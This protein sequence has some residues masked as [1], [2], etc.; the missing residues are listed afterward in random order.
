MNGFFAKFSRGFRTP[1]DGLGLIFR[2]KQTFIYAAIPFFI[3]MLVLMFGVYWGYNYLGGLISGFITG[4]LPSSGWFFSVLS[5]IV[6]VLA[7]LAFVTLLF[8]G[9]YI[10]LSILCGPFLSLMT[11]GILKQ[12]WPEWTSKSSTSLVIRMFLLSLVKA[13]LFVFISCI[14]FILAFLPP[15]NFVGSFLVFLMIAFDCMDYSFEVDLMSL[16]QRFQFFFDHF[17]YFLGTTVVLSLMAFIPGLLFLLLPAVVAGA[18]RLFVDL[19]SV[20]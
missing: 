18:A 13:L 3:G 4:Y 9:L 12:S 10:L 15:L 2:S 5:G 7:S 19:R 14:C 17:P 1:V 11:E 16:G 20:Q 6:Q 8:V